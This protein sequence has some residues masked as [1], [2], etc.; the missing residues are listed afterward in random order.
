MNAAHTTPSASGAAPATRHGMR[1]L[2]V[3]I[4]VGLLYYILRST[5]LQDIGAVFARALDRWPLL[6]VATVLPGL[7]TLAAVLRWRVLLRGLGARPSLGSLAHAYLVG[8]FFNQ[9]LPSTIGGDM[10]RGWW[11]K[12]T[13]DSPVQSLTVVGLDRVIGMVGICAV[14]L[15]AA[16]LRP[17]T[18]RE[19]PAFWAVLGLAT[20]GLVFL[21]LMSHPRTAALGRRLTVIPLFRPLQETGRTVY[22]ALHTFRRKRAHLMAALLYSMILQLIIIGQFVLLSVAF[23][24]PVSRTGLAAIVP[25]V[26]LVSLL[27]LA[28]NGIGLRESAL[29][30]LGAPLGLAVGDAIALAWAFIFFTFLYALVGGGLYLVGRR[31][32]APAAPASPV[33]PQVGEVRHGSAPAGGR[34]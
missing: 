29:A 4:S 22:D 34:V 13:V 15:L 23:D 16:V 10:V 26:T 7:G 3:A 9:F 11:M 31:D 27:P 25:V 8:H 2:R 14:G 6:L 19:L 17:D 20:L 32:R 24:L 18:I 33:G 12:H 5:S 30:V 21:A 1:L 28:I